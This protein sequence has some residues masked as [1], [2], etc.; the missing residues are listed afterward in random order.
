MSNPFWEHSACQIHPYSTQ[1]NYTYSLLFFFMR[2]DSLSQSPTDQCAENHS[3][4][5]LTDELS[6]KHLD[7]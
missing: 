6:L 2:S 7:A 1:V 4:T 3:I 5:I